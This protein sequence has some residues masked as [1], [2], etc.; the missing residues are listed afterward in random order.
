MD[1]KSKTYIP[2]TYIYMEGKNTKNNY[3]LRPTAKGDKQMADYTRK[4]HANW[5]YKFG[6]ITDVARAVATTF[7]ATFDVD[8]VRYLLKR[9]STDINER[10]AYLLEIVFEELECIL[11]YELVMVED[12]YI[13]PDSILEE[14]EE[15]LIE[16]SALGEYVEYS[17]KLKEYIFNFH[18]DV[19]EIIVNMIFD[20]VETYEMG[21]HSNFFYPEAEPLFF[22]PKGE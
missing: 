5:N 13:D 12:L 16:T 6:S 20:K 10:T 2:K 18:P 3:G 21:G 11:E 7:G 19:V 4:P 1:E 9:K 8:S 17:E 15:D 14:E 22:I